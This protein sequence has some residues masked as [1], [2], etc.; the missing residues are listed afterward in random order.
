M[1]DGAAT[2]PLAVTQAR[3]AEGRAVPP[4]HC[5]AALVRVQKGLCPGHS[6]PTWVWLSH[7]PRPRKPTQQVQSHM[8]QMTAAADRSLTH[9]NG[10]R[11]RERNEQLGRVGSHWVRTS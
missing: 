11:D 8:G 9:V 5:H 10:E 7:S 6:R 4:W 3:E 1:R 2:G